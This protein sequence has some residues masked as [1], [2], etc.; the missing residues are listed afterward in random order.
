M[1][2]LNEQS[3][4][5]FLIFFSLINDVRD[6]LKV[7]VDQTLAVDEQPKSAVSITSN[8]F[9]DWIK[10]KLISNIVSSRST[11]NSPDDFTIHYG[12][13]TID[14]DQDDNE[15]LKHKLLYRDD[16]DDESINT[17][18]KIFKFSDIP[19]RNKNI[20]AE[21]LNQIK[22][23][24]FSNITKGSAKVPS[25]SDE[26]FTIL[27]DIL[28]TPS[29]NE[30]IS[31]RDDIPKSP[32]PPSSN[33]PISNRDIIPKS[34]CPQSSNKSISKRDDIP[35][36][37]STNGAI[38]KRNDIPTPPSTNEPISK[39]DDIPRPPST[40]GAIS[41]RNDIPTPPST[42]EPIS[43]G[44]DIPKPPSTNGA[45]SK[46]HDIPQPPPSTNEVI[47]NIKDTNDISIDV[48]PPPPLMILNEKNVYGVIET[49][50]S[51]DIPFRPGHKRTQSLLRHLDEKSLIQNE[52]SSEDDQDEKELSDLYRANSLMDI[53]KKKKKYSPIKNI[54]RSS[55]RKDVNDLMESR[56]SRLNNQLQWLKDQYD[57]VA[58]YENTPLVS[59]NRKLDAKISTSL[60]SEDIEDK[61]H[62]R[63]INQ[64]T[65]KVDHVH[66]KALFFFSMNNS[67]KVCLNFIYIIVRNCFTK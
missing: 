42:N 25:T 30:P 21:L 38:S 65:N 7:D 49:T 55:T 29:S 9:T 64:L 23:S 35:K 3:S 40:N 39:G 52:S 48:T 41:K 61:V 8:V 28:K 62:I 58:P 6:K 24:S 63:R 54:F 16:D 66:L 13:V 14:I 59:K 22:S 20:P 4:I 27:D 56:E 45:I 12:D 31:K 67:L 5:H 10:N 15:E 33:Q 43:K 47:N 57:S 17:A 37:T 19:K 11:N 34:P 50:K 60:S 2:I 26:N 44:D 1:N 51:K 36:P 18:G 53:P 32:S 46:R